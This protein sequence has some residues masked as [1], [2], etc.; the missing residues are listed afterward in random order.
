[1]SDRN[2]KYI[3]V[4]SKIGYIHHFVFFHKQ[5]KSSLFLKSVMN[6]ICP[7]VS[8]DTVENGFWRAFWL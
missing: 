5:P 2:C 3:N 6:K 1:M 4:C 7:N 8:A